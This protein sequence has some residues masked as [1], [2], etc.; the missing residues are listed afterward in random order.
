MLLCGFENFESLFV[1][2]DILERL[3][4]IIFNLNKENLE[5]SKRNK[6]VTRNA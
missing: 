4:V 6:N 1:R 2:I 5:K 3:F